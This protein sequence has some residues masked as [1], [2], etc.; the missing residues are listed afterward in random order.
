M[1]RNLVLG[2]FYFLNFSEYSYNKEGYFNNKFRLFPSLEC[3]RY[4]NNQLM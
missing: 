3:Y 4:S 2:L 1:I